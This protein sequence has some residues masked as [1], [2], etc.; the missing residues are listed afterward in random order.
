M[1]SDS[2]K[3]RNGDGSLGQYFDLG[4]N[5]KMVVGDEG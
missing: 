2:T 4:D 3:G 5:Q 1:R